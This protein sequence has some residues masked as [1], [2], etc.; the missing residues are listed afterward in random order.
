MKHIS[1]EDLELVSRFDRDSPA[2]FARDLGCL[3]TAASASVKRTVEVEVTPA[4]V[5]DNLS[6]LRLW[7]DASVPPPTICEKALGATSAKRVRAGRFLVHTA[8]VGDGVITLGDLRLPTSGTRTRDVQLGKLSQLE[9]FMVGL[10]RPAV[11]VFRSKSLSAAR[12][13]SR[14]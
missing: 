6:K 12:R 14:Q 13:E 5:D 11:E 1:S 4:H 2:A 10:V 7:P 9:N 8:D 3:A